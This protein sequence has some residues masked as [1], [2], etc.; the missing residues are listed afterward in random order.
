MKIK[1]LAICALTSWLSNAALAQPQIHSFNEN[2]SYALF[3][4]NGTGATFIESNG[5]GTFELHICFHRTRLHNSFAST[6]TKA[7]VYDPNYGGYGNYQYFQAGS[8]PDESQESTVVLYPDTVYTAY[9]AN[10]AGVAY[11]IFELD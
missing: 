8:G 6:N 5:N 4:P 2:N 10:N 3:H 1:L 7:F 11:I 9:I